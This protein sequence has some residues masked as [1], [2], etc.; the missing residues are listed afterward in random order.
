MGTASTHAAT[1]SGYL[2]GQATLDHHAVVISLYSPTM[3]AGGLLQLFSHTPHT[4]VLQAH[5]CC[6]MAS[7]LQGQLYL[8][9][10]AN[11]ATG[12]CLCGA[13]GHEPRQIK[14]CSHHPCLYPAGAQLLRYDIREPGLRCTPRPIHILPEG[15]AFVALAPMCS[16]T[17][18]LQDR[19][20]L[21]A[22]TLQSV[23]L[24]D[25]RRP[26]QALLK[27]PHGAPFIIHPCHFICRAHM[28]KCVWQ[29]LSAPPIEAERSRLWFILWSSEGSHCRFRRTPCWRTIC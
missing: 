17:S 7:G 25:L 9:T 22:S 15:D 18:A 14:H 4:H 24:L 8:Q 12:G 20:L 3:A 13:C 11:A 23:L 26:H 10:H 28:C 2:R 6:A 5:G 1:S 27:W 16:A 29:D 19:R 21:A